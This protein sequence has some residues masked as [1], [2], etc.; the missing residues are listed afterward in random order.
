[1][2]FFA[3]SEHDEL[4]S[5]VARFLR[6]RSGPD[7]A[8]RLMDTCDGY[9]PLV[10]AQLTGQLGLAGLATPVEYGGAGAGFQELVTVLEQTG[11]VLLSAPYLA[12][13]VFAGQALLLAAE[14][15]RAEYIRRVASGRLVATLASAFAEEG[16][17]AGTTARREAETWLLDADLDLVLNAGQ[18]EVILFVAGGC[19]GPALFAVEPAADGVEIIPRAALDQTRRFARVRLQSVPARWLGPMT[20]AASQR[21]GQVVA[22]ALAAEAIGGA[23]A[24]L[25]AS[26][27]YARLRRQF[28]RP[29]GS[30]QAIQH[31]C[32][33]TLTQLENARSAVHYAAWALDAAD[34][35]AVT[36]VGVAVI[37]A[38]EAF[39][40][41][42]TEN[43][44]IHGGVGFTWE[45][46]A[47]LYLKRA[48]SDRLL[49]DPSARR[50]RLLV[51]LGV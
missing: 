35:D 46:D 49:L 27:G 12:S 15:A 28:G 30:F 16:A 5:S 40:H 21:L 44:Q 51:D 39:F 23:A 3:S 43:I 6:E 14:P 7:Q 50:A 8:R 32:A 17:A 10:W 20:P 22:L 42:A 37:A 31:K 45:H 9:D 26:V 34:P 18:A 33:D 1:V 38:T 47:H 25:D 11:R 24:C 19:D 36:A 4:Q 2:I 13:A 29:I 41:A 48:T